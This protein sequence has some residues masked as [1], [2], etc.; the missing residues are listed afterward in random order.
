MKDFVV[1]KGLEGRPTMWGLPINFFFI[2]AGFSIIL[3]LLA[4]LIQ[5]II[6]FLILSGLVGLIYVILKTLDYTNAIGILMTKLSNIPELIENDEVTVN[7][8][9]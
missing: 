2:W 4:G 6:A 5:K 9:K 7:K 1:E 3:L 8:T